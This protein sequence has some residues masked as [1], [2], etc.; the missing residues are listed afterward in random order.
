[1]DS[2]GPRD[3]AAVTVELLSGFMNMSRYTRQSFRMLKV[4]LERRGIPF[5]AATGTSQNLEVAGRLMKAIAGWSAAEMKWSYA[6]GLFSRACQKLSDDR[7]QHDLAEELG[8]LKEALLERLG[9]IAGSLT[10]ERRIVDGNVWLGQDEAEAVASQL[11]PKLEKSRGDIEAMLFEVVTLEVLLLVIPPPPSPLPHPFAPFSITRLLSIL[12]SGHGVSSGHPKN[13]AA[14]LVFHLNTSSR[15]PVL[16]AAIVNVSCC[17]FKHVVTCQCCNFVVSL[18]ACSLSYV[19]KGRDNS[20]LGQVCL[21][22]SLRSLHWL[23]KEYLFTA[24]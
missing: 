16:V 4:M 1:M 11:A 8:G 17:S 12:F 19:G 9:G 3:F 6:A 22:Q 21:P 13:A 10:D 5:P 24:R 2:K 15:Q 7:A 18:S 20:S 23:A 14:V